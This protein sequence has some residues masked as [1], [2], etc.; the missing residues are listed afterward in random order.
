M[1]LRADAH[2]HLFESGYGHSF[3]A[4]PGVVIN[5]PTCYESLRRE[6]GIEQALVVGYEMDNHT[7]LSNDGLL[8]SYMQE[9]LTGYRQPA[10]RYLSSYPGI[11]YE[12]FGVK[13]KYIESVNFDML[14]D[15]NCALV[16]SV[17]LSMYGATHFVCVTRIEGDDVSFFDSWDT[18][19]QWGKNADKLVTMSQDEF[20]DIFNGYCLLVYR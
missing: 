8:W 19:Q 15:G 10:N 17:K 13:S 6:H 14:P 3:A 9:Q 12:L 1:P 16:C 2:I 4:R 20:N 18:N 5:E 7:L 11:M